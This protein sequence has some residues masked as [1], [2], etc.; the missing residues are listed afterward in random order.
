MNAFKNN[1][2]S[3]L[4][5]VGQ[6]L[7]PIYQRTYSCEKEQ[8]ARIWSDI[9]NLYQ[10]KGEGHFVG[11]IV[12]IDELSAAGYQRSMIIDGQQRLTTF[13]L[14]LTALRDYASIHNDCGVN[15]DKITNTLLLNQYETG[16]DKYK[17]LLTQSDKD[18]LI[19][20]IERIPITEN[21]KSRVLDNYNFFAGQIAK[22]EISPANLYDTIGKLQIVDIVLD[23]QY[24]DPQSI[25]ESLNSTGMDLKDSDLIRN[26]MLMGLNASAQI[27]VYNNIWRPTELLF[28]YEHQNELMNNFY[29]DYL[30]MK[31][32][33]I[34]IKNE[35]YKEFKTY[36]ANCGMSINDLCQ[37]IYKFAKYYADIYFCRSDDS[38]VLKSLYEDM[39][40]IRMD[41]SYPFILK[42][43]DDYNKGLITVEDLQE[44]LRL[45]VSYIIRRAVCNIPT[46]SLNKT[47]AIIKGHICNDDYLNSVKVFFIMLDSYKEFP[48]DERFISS[49][50][51][52]DIYTMKRCRY[53][54]G[55][56]ENWDNKSVVSAESL[57]IEHIIPQNQHLSADW[58]AMLGEDWSEIQ[59]KYLHTIGNLTLTSYNSEMSDSS[60]EE[61]L[62]MDGGFKQ[63]ALRINKYVI[64]QSKWS[65]KQIIERAE[66]LGEIAKKIW[67][68]PMLSED[69]IAP[70]RKID[71]TAPQYSINSYDQLNAYNTILFEKLN[72]RIFSLSTFVK[73]EFR[74]YHVAYKADTVF[75]SLVIQS[76]GIRVFIN[77]NYNMVI[78]PKGITRNVTEVGH[79]G[80]GDVEIF[81]DSL[82][83][84]DDVM[85]I[86]EQ[87]FQLQDVDL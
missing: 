41:V 28:N 20:K 57:T 59:K 73:R 25:F 2:Y 64:M 46:N 35:I 8:C 29:R 30:T 33:R 45:C 4:G 79:L 40:T 82:S 75:V 77:M 17:L 14:L 12:R 48:N 74:K 83:D 6:Y 51:E 78:D 68:Y 31:I 76:K 86:I 23:R 53:V 16:Y 13:T 43:Y 38:E 65:K 80:T 56:L 81:F 55:Q 9:V 1:I 70:Y 18:I 61:K 63:S 87:A 26:Y 19:K 71:D 67:S 47:F 15:P 50:L 24:D 44:I 11:S 37:D 7:I 49:F 84:I 39:K 72:T 58:K 62:D 54:L 3:Y 66:Q 69:K 10:C 32:G 42:V 27:N 85:I 22:L 34:P 21:L 5:V 60:F 52:R 36:R